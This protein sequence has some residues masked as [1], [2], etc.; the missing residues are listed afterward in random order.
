MES[1]K[2]HQSH[3]YGRSRFVNMNFK[4]RKSQCP[5]E[6]GFRKAQGSLTQQQSAVW[7]CE[8]FCKQ[9]LGYPSS[10]SPPPNHPTRPCSKNHSQKTLFHHTGP[11]ELKINHMCFLIS[12]SLCFSLPQRPEK[13]LIRH[14]QP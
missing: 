3:L 10:F 14:S 11:D 6:N 1:T 13:C 7:E 9:S 4:A 2:G 5:Y 12:P 8:V